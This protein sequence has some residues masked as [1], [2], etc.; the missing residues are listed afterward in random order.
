MEVAQEIEQE[1]YLKTD[2]IKLEIVGL[3][4]NAH[5]KHIPTVDFSE[6]A[7]EIEQET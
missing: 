4:H 3:G 7:Q 5:E 6:M 1:M 2:N